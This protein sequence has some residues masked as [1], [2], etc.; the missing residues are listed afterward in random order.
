MVVQRRNLQFKEECHP[1]LL[2]GKQSVYILLWQISPLIW[3]QFLYEHSQQNISA[4]EQRQSKHMLTQARMGHPFRHE[5]PSYRNEPP[6]FAI[7]TE[8]PPYSNEPRPFS[9]RSSAV[10]HCLFLCITKTFYKLFR[11]SGITG[12][13][14]KIII[15]QLSCIVLSLSLK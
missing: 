12:W 11:R 10:Q 1:T 15:Y 13:V 9:K 4:G 8:P 14:R 7:H 5:P 2:Q 6:K 3:W